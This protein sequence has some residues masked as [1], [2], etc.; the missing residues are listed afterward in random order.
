MGLII[1]PPQFCD[2]TNKPDERNG[3]ELLKGGSLICQI[4]KDVVADINSLGNGE[5]IPMCGD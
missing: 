3:D 2:A 5:V 1:E 4:S